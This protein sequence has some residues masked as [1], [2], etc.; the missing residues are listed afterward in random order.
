MSCRYRSRSVVRV[1]RSHS[2]THE[3]TEPSPEP[4]RGGRRPPSAFAAGRWARRAARPPNAPRA[5]PPRAGL[6]PLATARS[7]PEVSNGKGSYRIGVRQV[8][9]QA[10]S[11]EP[12]SGRQRAAIAATMSS[13]GSV[14]AMGG[15]SPGR[16]GSGL[17]RARQRSA[18]AWSAGSSGS[19]P[20]A[21]AH[22]ATSISRARSRGSVRTQTTDPLLASEWTTTLGRIACDVPALQLE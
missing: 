8:T 12:S 20:S 16:S 19:A 15:S 11:S 3:E 5:R 21:A 13:D 9:Y 17:S 6:P 4:P 7:V 14:S 10:A 1:P 2:L 18:M 22:A